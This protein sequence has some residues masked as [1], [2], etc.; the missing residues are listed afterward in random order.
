MKKLLLTILLLCLFLTLAGFVQAEKTTIIDYPDLSGATKPGKADPGEE[1][2]RLIQYIFIFSLSIVGVIGLAAITIG[3]F[4]YL[5]AVG[6]PQKAADAKDKIFSALLGIILL[7]GSFLLLR[8]INPD[9]LKLGVDV[10]KVTV[11][12][13]D[14]KEEGVCRFLSASWDKD[15]I[16][17]GESAILTIKWD[18]ESC[19]GKTLE[20]VNLPIRQERTGTDLGCGKTKTEIEK[21]LKLSFP[22]NSPFAYTYTFNKHCKKD[23]TSG[24]N[25]PQPA[26]MAP[27][28]TDPKLIICN[29]KEKDED[30]DEP[31]KE[32]FYIK[33]T[34][35]VNGQ[36]EQDVPQLKIIVIDNK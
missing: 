19:K 7:L 2:P 12:I 30:K 16:D 31:G 27:K 17:A 15:N 22:N 18:K 11:N 1:L 34:I 25:F 13:P 9:L 21:I 20:K 28:P 33:G 10:P 4:G 14:T 24:I 35:K 23:L 6:N 3:A 36:S 29:Y 26:C 8:T 32:T 5:T